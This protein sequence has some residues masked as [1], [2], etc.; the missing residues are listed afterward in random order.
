MS[1]QISQTRIT[2]T[3]LKVYSSHS[4][5]GWCF[6]TN[7]NLDGEVIANSYNSGTGGCTFIHAMEGKGKLLEEAEAFAKNLPAIE[8]DFNDPK[9]GKKM[10]HDMDLEFLIELLVSDMQ[11]EKKLRTRF[12]R[13]FPKKL[14]YVKND[15]LYGISG[16]DISKSKDKATLLAGCRE[17]NGKDIIILAE[18]P[19]AK[20][21]ELYQKTMGTK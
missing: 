4:H 2:L 12:K 19:E 20:A 15:V 1:Q 13:E 21:W 6:E 17:H 16:V 3:S 8:S 9:T 5:E 11:H 14:L 7:V 18:L 10:I